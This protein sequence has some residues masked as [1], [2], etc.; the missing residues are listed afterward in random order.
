M[1]E[2]DRLGQ[3][4]YQARQERDEAQ[5]AAST[6]WEAW[7]DAAVYWKAEVQRL[8]RQNEHQRAGRV[9]DDSAEL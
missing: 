9:P 1:T 2:T 6:Y 8:K 4:L 3:L 5:E 7:Q